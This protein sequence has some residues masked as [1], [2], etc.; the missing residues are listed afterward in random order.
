M[1]NIFNKITSISVQ[2]LEDLLD[3]SIQLIDVRSAAEFQN[4]HIAQAINIP[5]QDIQ[6][7]Q[8]KKEDKVY[9]IC[10]SGARS[11]MATQFLNGQG[12]QAI[13]VSGGMNQ[14]QSHIE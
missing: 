13:N 7:F 14:W 10:Q 6:T 1:F 2:E 4:G 9:L 5:L 12:Y 11:R 8:G 3:Q